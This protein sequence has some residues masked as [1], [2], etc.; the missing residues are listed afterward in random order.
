[1]KI[2][3]DTAQ[4]DG[5]CELRARDMQ[6]GV[7]YERKTTAEFHKEYLLLAS[8]HP[9]LERNELTFVDFFVEGAYETRISWMSVAL[10]YK[11]LCRPAPSG[12]RI[13]IES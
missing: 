3:I 7:L 9:G 10:D 2:T 13:V 8:A 4:S 11:F 5:F 12:V 6:L 1:M